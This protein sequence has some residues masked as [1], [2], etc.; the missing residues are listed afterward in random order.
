MASHTC[1]GSADTWNVGV[2]W[3]LHL[4]AP[5]GQCAQHRGVV[6]SSN[7]QLGEGGASRSVMSLRLAPGAHWGVAYLCLQP[8]PRL[9]PPLAPLHAPPTTPGCSPGSAHHPWLLPRLCPPSRLLPSPRP[10][11]LA[12]PQALP[13]VPGSSPGPAHSPER[14][15]AR[16]TSG[17]RS[18]SAALLLAHVA[19]TG[20]STAVPETRPD[21]L[22]W[23]PGHRALTEAEF[24]ADTQSTGK[25]GCCEAAGGPATQRS[26]W[27]G[28]QRARMP[29][30][31][32]ARGRAW[33]GPFRPGPRLASGTRGHALPP[34]D[35]ARAARWPWP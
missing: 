32:C 5:R 10:P 26:W 17:R 30:A 19:G 25:S 14:P 11:H 9:R 24:S 28:G 7:G 20:P 8:G 3:G 12:P 1:P 27:L 2:G 13:I 6:G 34:P 18:H 22:V 4:S 29:A 33:A 23:W 35:H 21:G 16:C 15:V 31:V